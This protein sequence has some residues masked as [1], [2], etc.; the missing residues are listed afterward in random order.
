MN[1]KVTNSTENHDL[2]GYA[3]KDVEN[4]YKS[5]SESTNTTLATLKDIDLYDDIYLSAKVKKVR[6]GY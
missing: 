4:N 5:I 3:D 2:L 1:D 6:R